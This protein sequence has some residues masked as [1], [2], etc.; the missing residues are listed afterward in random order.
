MDEDVCAEF[1]W[2]REEVVRELP[3]NSISLIEELHDVFMRQ[4]GDTKYRTYYIT[5]FGVLRRKNDE[6]IS[7]F[8]KHFNKMY[9]RIQL[10]SNLQKLQLR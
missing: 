8:C 10:K 4:W 1:G 6:T 2:G 3:A 9:G 5:E 7:E